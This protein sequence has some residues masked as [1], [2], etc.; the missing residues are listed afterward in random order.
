MDARDSLH[1]RWLGR[2]YEASQ[3]I[4]NSGL[5]ALLTASLNL[6]QN[7]ICIRVGSPILL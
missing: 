7:E 4:G 1:F 3:S 5:T 6:K 2:Q